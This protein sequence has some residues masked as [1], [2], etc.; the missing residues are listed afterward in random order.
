MSFTRYLAG[1]T[2]LLSFSASSAF[3]TLITFDDLDAD[4]R[5]L[6]PWSDT[7]PD[8]AL[9]D[10]GSVLVGR[11]LTDQYVGLGLSFGTGDRNDIASGQSS[12][13]GAAL[14]NREDVVVSG[15]NAV[16][17]HY[18]HD[19]LR[20]WF[21][22]DNR[23]DYLSFYVS[24]PSGGAMTVY[25]TESGGA[26][27]EMQLGYTVDD[28]GLEFTDTPLKH[29][30]EFFSEGFESVYLSNFYGH[31]STPVY[32][33]NLYFGAAPVSAPASL[34]LLLVGMAGVLARRRW[35]PVHS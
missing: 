12:A 16:S 34:P 11:P 10:D 32:M 33:D 20:F 25:V 21:V 35:K 23:P 1:A 18:S 17:S 7:Y 27:Q 31:R 15:P 8:D 5:L 19:G 3:A 14:V 4:Y 9:D 26:V 6:P 28:D 24:A 22:G 2:V 30:V 13:S 29:Q